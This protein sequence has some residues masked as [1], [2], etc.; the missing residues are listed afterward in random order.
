MSTRTNT[1]AAVATLVTL[2]F[3]LTV[4][5][6]LQAGGRQRAVAVT[7]PPSGLSLTVLETGRASTAV[8]DAGTISWRGGRRRYSVTARTFA[9]RIGAASREARG[10]ATVRAFLE[11]P[12]PHATIRIDGI[13]L[14]AT[15]RIVQRNAPIGIAVTHRLEI[16]V[17][18]SAPEGAVAANI[19]WEITTE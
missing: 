9:M 12:D 3:S 4:S 5:F 7:P 11:T 17:P 13:V 15:P 14:S 10:T 6:D 16:E 1:P 19:G 18:V 2:Y 8:V